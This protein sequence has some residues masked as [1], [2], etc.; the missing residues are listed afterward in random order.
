MVY[1]D[2]NY[3]ESFMYMRY[4]RAGFTP[5]VL[6]SKMLHNTN[7]LKLAQRYLT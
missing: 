7:G 3:I 4:L 5:F 2:Y 1:N 6:G